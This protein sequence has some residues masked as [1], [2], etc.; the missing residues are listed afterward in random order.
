MKKGKMIWGLGL[1]IAGLLLFGDL[2]GVL[3]SDINW[4]EMTIT[5]LLVVGALVNLVSRKYSNTIMLLTIVV[6]VNRELLSIEGN[7]WIILF[8]GILLSI[9]V[10]LVFKDHSVII[11]MDNGEKF[12]MAEGQ[13]FKYA[14][15]E[16]TIH[17]TSVFGSNS[18]SVR[19]DNLRFIK[20]ESVMGSLDLYLNEAI[21][22]NEA[23]IKIDNVFSKTRI[24]VNKDVNVVSSLSS[25]FGGVSESNPNG[26]GN[27][28]LLRISG[29]NV[30]A[31]IEIIYI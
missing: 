19:T 24:Y 16:G 22:I 29:D 15:A 30:F 11:R 3:P 7:I 23:S 5:A 4:F 12:T 18:R 20:V 10:S 26:R 21:I 1:I 25:V 17:I 6:I 14:E 2:L 13:K 28:P 31:G 27:G 9:G 8:I